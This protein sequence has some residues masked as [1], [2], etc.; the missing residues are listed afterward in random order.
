MISVMVRIVEV[1]VDGVVKFVEAVVVPLVISVYKSFKVYMVFDG[2]P[3]GGV[4]E[5]ALAIE[6]D[7]KKTKTANK[8]T[9][10]LIFENF[11]M[12][13]LYHEQII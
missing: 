7:P 5:P 12:D 1:A 6:N 2:A 3:D 10:L 13:L 8:N 4:S 11:M 9:F